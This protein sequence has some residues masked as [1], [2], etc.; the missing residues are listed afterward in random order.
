MNHRKRNDSP[1]Q[2]QVLDHKSAETDKYE[3]SWALDIKISRSFILIF[4]TLFWGNFQ[5][6]LQISRS[7]WGTKID[8]SLNKLN[9]RQFENEIGTKQ[10]Q[11]MCNLVNLVKSA[12]YYLNKCHLKTTFFKKIATA[13]HSR[14]NL[15]IFF[16]IFFEGNK[17]STT[18]PYNKQS[19]KSGL[20]STPGKY[21]QF[22]EE[23]SRK[24][25]YIFEKKN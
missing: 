8:D 16:L 15:K 14:K 2:V 4:E 20:F 22:S 12:A 25:M 24:S 13:I 21:L 18:F 11:Q 5:A 10:K 3:I 9:K 19:I 17:Q 1:S 23:N 6:V 7:E